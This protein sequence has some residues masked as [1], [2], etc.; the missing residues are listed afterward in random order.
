MDPF[1]YTVD[2]GRVG[3][4]PAPGREPW[5]LKDI[6]KAGFAVIVS[7]ECDRIDPD[8]IRA[9]GMEHVKICVE[10]FQPPT[11]EQ[12]RGFNEMCDRKVAEGKKVLTHCWAGRGRTGTFLASRL[13]W[14]GMNAA[15]A[16]AEVRQKIL[17]TQR[18]L[19][20]AIESSQEAALFAF[21]RTLRPAK[22]A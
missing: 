16:I 5:D 21:E 9:A 1:I 17:K 18:T 7:F 6:K 20:G 4:R 13:I 14:R 15:D 11:L 2:M 12:L 22:R 3:G 10:D 8:E 19:A